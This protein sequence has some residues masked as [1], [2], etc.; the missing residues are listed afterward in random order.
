LPAISERSV[1]W[2]LYSS[3][4]D[5]LLATF[6]LEHSIL[7]S[8]EMPLDMRLFNHTPPSRHTK[9]VGFQVRRGLE[10][11]REVDETSSS[12]T[13]REVD[14]TSS[15]ETARDLLVHHL[16]FSGFCP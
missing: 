1:L 7:N 2:G 10:T 16:S 5:S 13:A 8:I 11:G 6:H 9:R 4:S 3:R 12:D 15:S 14:D